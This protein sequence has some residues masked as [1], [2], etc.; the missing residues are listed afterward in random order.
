MD[1]GG[2]GRAFVHVFP[3]A[4]E[5]DGETGGVVLGDAEEL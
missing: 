2:E 5:K 1:G 3:K 4:V